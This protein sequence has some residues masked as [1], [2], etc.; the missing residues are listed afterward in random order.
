MKPYDQ[1]HL[2]VRK[3]PI[4]HG[5]TSVSAGGGREKRKD[6]DPKVHGKKLE[7]E[8]EAAVAEEE[9]AAR[10]V[11][12]E[13]QSEPGF[14]LKLKSLDSTRKGGIELL[15]VREVGDV[16]F[17]TVL[18]PPD[19]LKH[20]RTLFEKYIN[21]KTAK[22][23]P[24]N[25]ALLN[26]IST[27]RR[28]ALKSVWTELGA[29]LP[30]A[31]VRAWFE[32]WLRQR[33]T[34]LE[35]FTATAKRLG[36]D[37]VATK[38]DFI[39]RTV[40]L[41]GGTPEQLET[42]FEEDSSIAEVRLAR[43]LASDFTEMSGL[44][45]TAWLTNLLGRLEGPADSAPAVCLLDTG[46]NRGHQLLSVA[47]GEVDMHAYDPQWRFDDH[48]GHGTALAGIAL[49][50]DLA[51]QL[52][53]TGPLQLHHRLES[54]KI[55]PPPPGENDP[56]LWGAITDEAVARAEIAAPAR[57]RAICLAVTSTKGSDAG[58]PSSWS[59]ALD[60]LAAGYDTGTRRLICVSAGNVELEAFANY[61]QS[62][63]TQGVLDPAQAWNALTIGAVASRTNIT[64]PD[65][66]NWVPI[67][68][69]GD[70]GPSTSTSLTWNARASWPLKPDL[71]MDGGNAAKDSTGQQVDCPD[72]LSLLTTHRLAIG[73]Q[74]A[75]TGD[76]SAATALAAR[77]AARLHAQHPDYW[78]ETIRALM[79]HSAEW[80]EPMIRRYPATNR[81]EVEQ[82]LRCCGHGVPHE[83]AAFASALND[84]TVVIQQELQPFGERVKDGKRE[85]VTRDLHLHELP[86]P[87]EFLRSLGEAEL[88]L[89][90]TL[91]YFIEPSPGERGGESSY[92]YGSFGLRFDLQTPTE[93][94]GDFERRVN[95]Q[96]RD[97][98]GKATSK[99]DSD[100]W[101]LGTD[102]RAK[103]SV[104]SD[105]WT[106]TGA[107]L[108]GKGRLAVFPAIGW[109]KE[110]KHLGRWDTKVRYGLVLSIRAREL[111]V[112]VYTP[113]KNTIAVP[114]AVP[115]RTR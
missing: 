16:T 107:E 90:V 97:D 34:P 75:T 37:T 67:A 22:G 85:I 32:V 9:D 70:L 11:R 82:R 3:Q 103:G 40:T 36:L 74:F 100:R 108:A 89:R 71:L 91:S 64:E 105:T 39:D 50:G 49:Y 23:S 109:W 51:H 27:V 73:R 44:D 68:A 31:G 52:E 98:D 15:S 94:D 10:P 20:F 80:T 38:L 112:D 104:H 29:E 106:G 24:R 13:F 95:R 17:A 81:K 45:Q 2:M 25:A 55:L 102:L 93:S 79:V 5:F 76:T 18:I 88:Q 6:R 12:V 87:T 57:A 59:A 7:K 53:A 47:L 41:F 113:I 33:G 42:L 43:A 78:P 1:P 110:R 58:R 101:T 61:P 66:E 96:A 83:A 111:D 48:E 86:W 26:S 69:Q 65:Y 60:K 99:G 21:E 92:R 114:V 35:K 62:N 8:F 4:T 54:V 14:D 19:Q 115:V 28:A 30:K 72:S 46:V 84:A 77:F 56:K 63:E